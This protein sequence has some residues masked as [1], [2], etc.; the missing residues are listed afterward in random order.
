MLEK[1][2]KYQQ[3]IWIY[4]YSKQRK[5][6]SGNS[7]PELIFDHMFIKTTQAHLAPVSRVTCNNTEEW[8][9]WN[10]ES[11]IYIL[12]YGYVQFWCSLIFLVIVFDR[13]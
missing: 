4:I 6:K 8:E 3:L 12:I 11:S 5:Y 7:T 10:C 13:K 9:K 2:L 1:G